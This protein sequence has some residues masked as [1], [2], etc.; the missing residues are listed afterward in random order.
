ML[1]ACGQ[2]WVLC[3]PYESREELEQYIPYANAYEGMLKVPRVGLNYPVD[4]E[5]TH[6]YVIV[7]PKRDK[8]TFTHEWRH[9]LFHLDPSVRRA[10]MREWEGLSKSERRRV[11]QFMERAGYPEDK[12]AD[13]YQ[14][15][16][17]SSEKHK[18]W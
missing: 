18:V 15:Y 3:V 11:E 8:C 5:P 7:Y 14:A 17:Y 6:H 13:E 12:W 9:A 1:R 4:N 16:K 10:C 2:K